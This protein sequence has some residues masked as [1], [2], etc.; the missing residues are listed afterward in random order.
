VLHTDGVRVAVAAEVQ[1]L[2]TRVRNGDADGDGQGA[3]VLSLVGVHA[4][5]VG[6]LAGAADA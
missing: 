1:D 3:A 4:Q 2:E 6:L 5:H